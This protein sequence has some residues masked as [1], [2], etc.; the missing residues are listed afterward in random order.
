MGRK[1]SPGPTWRS[2]FFSED[3]GRRGEGRWLRHRGQEPSRPNPLLPHTSPAPVT[4]PLRVPFADRSHRI[5]DKLRQHTPVVFE[6]RWC[7]AL[8]R[9]LPAGTGGIILFQDILRQKTAH[10]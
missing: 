1:S 2:E 7:H 8:Q 6:L 3:T 5:L 4:R 9:T 10:E